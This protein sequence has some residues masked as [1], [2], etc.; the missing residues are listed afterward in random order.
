MA[1]VFRKAAVE[2]PFFR[3]K[4]VAK[5]KR[6]NNPDVN[7]IELQELLRSKLVVAVIPPNQLP[8]EETSINGN[9]LH[10][11]VCFSYLYGTD[12]DRSSSLNSL[13]I[14]SYF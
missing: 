13:G 4:L 5:G 7:G 8:T 9:A 12:V 11:K 14:D 10:S 1:I 3:K 2:Q 6:A